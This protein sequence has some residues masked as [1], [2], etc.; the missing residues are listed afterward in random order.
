MR[1]IA[2]ILS[3]L[4]L[5]A[6]AASAQPA[7]G[8]SGMTP[9]YAPPTV[10]P[11]TLSTAS[12]LVWDG[13]PLRYFKLQNVSATA[14]M[15]CAWNATPVANAAGSMEIVA[16]ASLIY[17]KNFLPNAALNC[18]GSAAATGTLETN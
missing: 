5:S 8:V 3:V 16:G 14:V 1:L 4:L 12:S 9:W 15:W 7:S 18:L 11:V 6:S 17:D 2:C 10:T 13:G